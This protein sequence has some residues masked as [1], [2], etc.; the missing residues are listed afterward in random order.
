MIADTAR[1]ST[2]KD[3]PVRV[4]ADDVVEDRPA[5]SLTPREIVD[6]LNRYIIGQ[7]DAKRAVAVALRN[8]YRRQ[9]LPEE[10]RREVQ[11][12]NILM[13]GSTGVGKTEIARRVARIVD[14]PFIKVEA[15]KF[16][17][18]GYVGRDVE[19][20]V[21]DLVEIAITMIHSQRL[22]L[23]REE[24]R[25]AAVERLAEIM[26]EQALAQRPPRNSSRR[27]GMDAAEDAEAVAR[28]EAQMFERR[29]RREQKRLMDLLNTEQ[30]DDETVEI[31]L[32]EGINYDEAGGYDYASGAP[33]DEMQES[34]YD[35]LDSLIPRRRLRRRV[36]VREAR[37]I[38]AQ[39]EA[40]R[41][42]DFDQ[43][44]ETAIKRVED[45]AVVFIDEIDKTISGDGDS[46]P[47]I[48]G[49]GVQRDLLPIVE[50]SAVMTRYGPIH[51][52]HVLFIAAGSFSKARPSDLIPE[53]QGRFPIRVEL[54]SLSEDDLYA[55]LTE[56]QNALTK[57][58]EALLGTEGFTLR[59][60]E[61]GLREVARLANQVNQRSEDIGARRLQTILE[62]VI[63]ELSFDASDRCGES[64]EIGK[65]FVLE[66][67]GE[68]VDDEE[69]SNFI[70]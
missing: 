2:G 67:V 23:V 24:A 69:L 4:A 19:S 48:S 27:E 60:S 45:A 29:R 64:V 63:E 36:S 59:F 61:D 3:K 34:I 41:L 50:G 62:R 6:E 68:V 44:V 26:S 15:T 55:I 46:G 58:Y 25:L 53:L 57:Q 8:R 39:Q 54:Q 38:L 43:V 9:Q 51:T 22:E 37:R 33:Y 49:E 13:I 10:L 52:D 12:K 1:R 21:R 32:D 66:R 17:E 14:A 18:V 11:P 28:R 35:M 20:I 56:P 5:D 65:D 70:L 40:M 31:E 7:H 47:D 42:V 16:T 30:I